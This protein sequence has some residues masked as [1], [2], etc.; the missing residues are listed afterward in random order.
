MGIS[1]KYAKKLCKR[2][3]ALLKQDNSEEAAPAAATAPALSKRGSQG[4]AAV[5]QIRQARA[6]DKASILAEHAAG[7]H[8]SSGCSL[9]P[10][11]KAISPEPRGKHGS[12]NGRVRHSCFQGP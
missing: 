9:K 11:P 10:A 6:D 2:L 4:L 1:A 3:Q 12:S 5:Q 8:S 7:S